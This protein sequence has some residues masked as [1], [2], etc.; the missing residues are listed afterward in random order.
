MSHQARSWDW[1]EE[2]VDL[3]APRGLAAGRAVAVLVD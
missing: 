3:P 2:A 1:S